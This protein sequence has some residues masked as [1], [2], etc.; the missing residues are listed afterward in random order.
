MA[1]QEVNHR[2]LADRIRS[3]FFLATPH[4][5]SDYA[6]VLNRI[7][8]V[9]GLAGAASSRDYIHD[10]TKGSAS[11]RTINE[12]FAQYAKTLSIYSFYET[13]P[14]SLGVTSSLIVEKDSAV[15]GMS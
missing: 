2:D 12:D 3:I 10:L 7:L 14:L 13:M 15:L 8:K 1:H 9:S 11:T 5:G 4:R 6:A